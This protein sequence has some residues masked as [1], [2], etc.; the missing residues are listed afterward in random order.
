MEEYTRNLKT[1]VAPGLSLGEIYRLVQP[2]RVCKPVTPRPPAS[3]RNPGQECV[4]YPRFLTSLHSKINRFLCIYGPPQMQTGQHD[5]YIHEEISFK[6][7]HKLLTEPNVCGFSVTIV[8]KICTGRGGEESCLLSSRWTWL[9][10]P[11]TAP[12]CYGFQ[13]LEEMA[14]PATE[15]RATATDISFA[16]KIF[17]C[18]QNRRLA[19]SAPAPN[20]ADAWAHFWRH[21]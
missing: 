7:Q 21:N 8:R 1:C 2:G 20:C 3:G 9:C 10:L 19:E 13:S 11:C 15:L 5:G 16:D 17:S 14:Q 12:L 6:A 18:S 4:R